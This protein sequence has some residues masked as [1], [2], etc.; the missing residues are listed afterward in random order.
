MEGLKTSLLGMVLF[1]LC[2]APAPTAA[3]DNLDIYT[4]EIFSLNAGEIILDDR[5]KK[6]TFTITPETKICIDGF[7]GESWQ[8]LSTA[9]TATVSTPQGS[10]VAVRIDNIPMVIDMGGIQFQPVLPECLARATV[11]EEKGQIIQVKEIQELLIKNGINTGPL[12]GKL[13]PRTAAAIRTFQKNKG[14]PETGQITP[15][16]LE[17]LKS[18]ASEKQPQ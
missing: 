9:K 13:G 12:D 14:V 2:L 4:G 10:T 6:K 16:L 7:V 5:Y 3:D 18:A 8:D 11:V 17:M 1:S 15:E